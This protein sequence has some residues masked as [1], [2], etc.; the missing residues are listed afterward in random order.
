MTVEQVLPLADAVALSLKK[1]PAEVAIG[2]LPTTE[3]AVQAAIS[4]D[5]HLSH[6]GHVIGAR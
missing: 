2:R 1:T 5:S 6:F 3:Q 4:L